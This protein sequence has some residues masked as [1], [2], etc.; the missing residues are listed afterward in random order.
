MRTVVR[1]A[2]HGRVNQRV[3]V[4]NASGGECQKVAV[5]VLVGASMLQNI[6]VTNRRAVTQHKYAAVNRVVGVRR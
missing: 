4:V 6:R 3:V 2:V 5:W 1:G